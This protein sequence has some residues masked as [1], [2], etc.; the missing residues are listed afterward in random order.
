MKKVLI[1]TY[2]WPPSGGSGVQRWVKFSKYLPAYGWKPVIYTPANPELLAV[3]NTLEDEIPAST[4]VLKKP[5]FEPYGIYRRLLGGKDASEGGSNEVNPVNAKKKTFM[6]KLSMFIRGNFFIPDPRCFWIAPSVCYLKKYLREHPVDVIVSTGPPHSMHLIARR[7]AK[8]TG[9]PWIADFRDPW[10]KMFYFKHLS[11]TRWTER[12]HERLEQKVLD[13]ASAVV[14]V[15]PMVQKDFEAMTSTRVE[16]ITNGFD[17][18]DFDDAVVEPDGYFNVTHTGLF[19]ADG[20][21]AALWQVLSQKCGQ[22][23]EFRKMLRIR[24]VGK[25]DREIISSIEDAGLSEYLRD[26]GYQPHTVAVK[27]QK[28]ASLLILPLRREPE[29]KA[30]IPGKLFEYLASGNPILGIGQPDGAMAMIVG[31]AKAGKVFDWEDADRIAGYVDE[32]WTRFR[33]G[34]TGHGTTGISQYSRKELT[35]RM[36]SLMDSLIVKDRLI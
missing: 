7:L 29:Y 19:A 14:A 28:C 2:Y 30:T 24:L 1:I 5:I 10:T 6:Q 15:S 20:N 31:S 4:T 33:A 34:N 25:T 8:A 16:L 18:S 35:S 32:C 26:N 21:P 9:T 12:R 13:E 3:D 27:E 22:D 11:L 23:V 36:A 17:E